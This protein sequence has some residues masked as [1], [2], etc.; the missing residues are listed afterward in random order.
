MINRIIQ[1]II[2]D[3]PLDYF[4]TRKR[5]E[6]E[7]EVAIEHIFHTTIEEIETLGV[8]GIFH[9]NPA[10]FTRFLLYKAFEQTAKGSY[11][12]GQPTGDSYTV[13]FPYV[14]V[15]LRKDAMQ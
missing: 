10:L 3:L 13:H 11:I 5:I 9:N 14:K 8:K 2:P 12:V 15:G 7:E 6:K 1:V 4:Q